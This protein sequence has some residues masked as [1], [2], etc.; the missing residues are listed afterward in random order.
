MLTL[1]VTIEWGRIYLIVP[2]ILL[3]GVSFAAMGSAIGAAAREV[4]ASALLAFAL[5]LPI[6]FLSL[7]PSGSVGPAVFDAIRYTTA[8]FP[9]KPALEAITAALD[10]AG[11]GIGG[12]LAHLAVL[13]CAYAAL[14]RLA[15][16]R[17]TAV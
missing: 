2:A 11:P 17:F 12:P 7:V 15:L 16:R 8:L 3:A 9:F 13:F 14:A 1:F 5:S 6:A 10:E 4:R